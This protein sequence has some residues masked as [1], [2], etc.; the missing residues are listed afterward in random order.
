LQVKLKP[1]NNERAGRS[2]PFLY[3]GTNVM[4][5]STI[6]PNADNFE[7]ESKQMVVL[8]TEEARV[9]GQT[10]ES[11]K[12]QAEM[13]KNLLEAVGIDSYTHCTNNPRT[14]ARLNLTIK[15]DNQS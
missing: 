6:V 15:Q 10:A 13:M 12:I 3:E 14:I 1:T 11:L 2:C 9:L 8:T 5:K 7:T 4:M